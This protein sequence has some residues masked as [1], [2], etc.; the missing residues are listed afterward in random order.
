MK[1]TILILSIAA[2]TLAPSMKS[3][4][5]ILDRLER[6]LLEQERKALSFGNTDL[7]EKKGA[8]RKFV[9][10]GQDIPANSAIVKDLSKLSTAIKDL[11]QHVEYLAGE[12]QSVKQKILHDTHIDNTVQ[13]DTML[14]KETN[15]AYRTISIEIDEHNIFEQNAASGLW[16]PTGSIPIFLGPMSPGK[17]K[18]KIKARLV[19]KGKTDLPLENGH[20][21]FINEVYEFTVPEGHV[22]KKWR[23]DIDS[24]SA[25][26][27][28]AKVA[29]KEIK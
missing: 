16:N 19:G 21:I 9:Y 24:N 23:I 7:R 14:T 29:M 22:F 18:L 1:T 12:V 8:K 4:E 6:R 28:S 26:T 20:F 13:I 17:H 3:N 5:T 25:S 10:K 11:D 27:S 2:M 15:L